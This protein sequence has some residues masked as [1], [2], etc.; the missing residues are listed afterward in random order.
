MNYVTVWL[1]I[2]TVLSI[3]HVRGTLDDRPEEPPTDGMRLAVFVVS[4]LVA[5][6]NAWAFLVCLGGRQ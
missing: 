4:V 1:G 5:V 6:C 2:L 3:M